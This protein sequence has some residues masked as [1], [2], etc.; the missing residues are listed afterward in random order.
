MLAFLKKHWHELLAM[1]IIMVLITAFAIAA[2]YLFP[3]YFAVSWPIMAAE[4]TTAIGP[5]ALWSI[6]AGAVSLV[7]GLFAL[8]I[9]NGIK[10]K[11]EPD[12][13]WFQGITEE[14]Y[15]SKPDYQPLES[16]DVK[17]DDEL[18]VAVAAKPVVEAVSASAP[19]PS[20]I[21][22]EVNDAPPRTPSLKDRMK[23]FQTAL[24]ADSEDF[25]H[26][27]ET[28]STTIL[29]TKIREARTLTTA[30][31]KGAARRGDLSTEFVS[32]MR[33]YCRHPQA[34][35]LATIF[36][37]KPTHLTMCMVNQLIDAKGDDLR[38]EVKSMLLQ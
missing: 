1:M 15:R 13:P 5:M 16:I 3:A 28:S 27:H 7:F 2:P 6:M 23:S 35:S 10:T 14:P 21:L 11:D 12:W 8:A 4:L 24:Q 29:L 19:A 20:I 33:E 38:E 32:D 30:Q 26:K 22:D 34:K 9:T 31:S 17:N 25:S 36:T 18:D 37:E